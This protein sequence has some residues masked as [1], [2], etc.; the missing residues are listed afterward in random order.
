MEN[1]SAKNRNIIKL[2]LTWDIRAGMEQSFFAYLSHELL[3]ALAKLTDQPLKL[4]E[5]WYTLYGDWPQ[6]RVEFICADTDTAK[7][8][9]ESPPWLE[10]KQR[11]LTFVENYRQKVILASGSFQV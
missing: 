6:M 10:L 3:P 4:T 9:L 11:L 8:F 7:Q 2:M 5:V 1:Q